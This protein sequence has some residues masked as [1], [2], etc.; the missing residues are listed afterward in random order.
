[1]T[2]LTFNPCDFFET[3][4]NNSYLPTDWKKAWFRSEHPDGCI[5]T[6]RLPD[7]GPNKVFLSRVWFDANKLE[8]RPNGV[9][10]ASRPSVSFIPDTEQSPELLHATELAE[11]IAIGRALTNAGYGACD[12][13]M[14]YGLSK[15]TLPLEDQLPIV[16]DSDI[17]VETTSAHSLSPDEE[18][19]NKGEADAKMDISKGTIPESVK[20]VIVTAADLLG[21]NDEQ[22]ATL[23]LPNTPA[24]FAAEPEPQTTVVER[25]NILI[26]SEEENQEPKDAEKKTRR[27]RRK[28]SDIKEVEQ[29]ATHPEETPVKF[30]ETVLNV[31]ITGSPIFA[32]KTVGDLLNISNSEGFIKF[33]AEKGESE[34]LRVA[35]KL[36]LESL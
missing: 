5:E 11:T 10:T 32:N 33:F 9:G 26:G 15:K 34:A 8:A 23:V 36:V 2:D 30:D 29:T 3:D 17:E 35:C 12:A 13:L 7:D 22:L 28:K 25:E 27:G 1:M 24:M 16:V 21:E 6:E 14:R 18:G 31:P 4:G 20:Q 19:T